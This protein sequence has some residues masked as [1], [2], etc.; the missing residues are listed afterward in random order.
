MKIAV[1]LRSLSSGSV[2]GVENYTLN[3]LEHLLAQDKRN[4]YLLF[5]NSFRDVKISDF[6][7]VNSQIK[8]TKIPNKVLNLAF[9]LGAVKLEK[10]IGP[11]DCLFMPNL[12]QFHISPQAKLAVTVHDLS[13]AVTPEFY[14]L[15]RDLWHK[16]LNYKKAFSRANV[17]FTVSEYTKK[18]LIRLYNVNEAKIKVA[19]PGIDRK[20]FNPDIPVSKLRQ[21]RNIYGLPGDYILFLNTIE[22]RKNLTSLVKAF[23]LLDYPADLVI[24]G[25]KGWKYREIF[26]Q[27]KQS[28]KFGRIKY[29][30]YVPEADKP[31]I[32]KL[33]KVLVYPSFYEGFGFQPLEAQACGVPTVVSQV[34]AL[35][36]VVGDASLLIDPYNVENLANA[37]KLILADNRLREKL[38]EKGLQR[39]K[40]FNWEKTASKV[41][42]ELN[43]IN[44]N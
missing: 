14:D 11:F 32:I 43:Q 26:R 7:Y 8:R 21:A 30:G 35:P 20:D 17:I 41:L 36:E 42:E 10:L 15:K 4:Q 25:R 31:A 37:L 33:A 40:E 12:S 34:T 16:F 28:K 1:D 22:P 5:Y 2:S 23:D 27:I 3:L 24:V 38:I 18:D 29:L 19:Y 13:P 39:V 44:L 6:H 9:K